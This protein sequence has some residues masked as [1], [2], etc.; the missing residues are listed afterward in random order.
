[1]SRSLWGLGLPL[2]LQVKRVRRPG[3][4]IQRIMGVRLIKRIPPIML[5][6]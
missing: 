6:P 3:M 2:R 1:L 4:R 5:M